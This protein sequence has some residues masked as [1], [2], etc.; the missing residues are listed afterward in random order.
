LQDLLVKR[1][2]RL[3]VDLRTL[4]SMGKDIGSRLRL[5]CLAT[6][7][8]SPADL[9]HFTSS[10]VCS[11][12]H[13]ASAHGGS[14][15]SRSGCSQSGQSVSLFV[16]AFALIIGFRSPQ[17]VDDNMSVRVADFGMSRIKQGAQNSSCNLIGAAE[18]KLLDCPSSV[19]WAHQFERRPSEMDES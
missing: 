2:P 5:T 18:L 12:G 16:R 1:S 17:L 6:A 13:P 8:K 14:Y 4:V 9:N 19:C 7:L 15:P 11:V 3:D 10:I